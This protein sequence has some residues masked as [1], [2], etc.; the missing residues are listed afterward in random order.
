[1]RHR[2]MR[3]ISCIED[4]AL[5]VLDRREL[6]NI[7]EKIHPE[8]LINCSEYI[9]VARAEADSEFAKRLVSGGALNMA[10]TCAK[11]NTVLI[12]ISTDHVFRGN[13]P[14]LLHERDYT[15]PLSQYG[16]TKLEGERIVAT[17]QPQHFIIRPGWIYSEY[18][19]NFMTALLQ[20]AAEREQIDVP[21]DQVGSPTYG[22]DLANAVLNM[23]DTG[24]H[25]H[26]KYGT[27]HYGNEGVSS[28][29]DFAK[30]LF[31]I[32]KIPTTI[33]PI[34]SNYYATPMN[35]P[36][37]SAMDKTKIKKTFGLS[38]PYWRDALET[39]L[40][41]LTQHAD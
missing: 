17:F 26:W 24:P 25:E 2:G 10:E 20:A 35:G 40:K 29:Y 38:I 34:I 5:N 22:M 12:H 1:M 27:Y 13:I 36:A 6:E 14:K 4:S 3:N 11:Y 23:I 37:F 19:N 18:G 33:N 15:E 21:A 30:A 28:L 8:F 7:F 16:H 31:D 9:D 32:A 41:N 39:C